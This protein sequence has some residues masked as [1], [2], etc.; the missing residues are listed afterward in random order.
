MP[1]TAQEEYLLGSSGSG[2]IATGTTLEI[3][4]ESGKHPDVMEVL[5]ICVITGRMV[6]RNFL[7]NFSGTS[8]RQIAFEPI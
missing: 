1:W 7:I 8:F 4:H 2:T 3:F 6:E 5:N